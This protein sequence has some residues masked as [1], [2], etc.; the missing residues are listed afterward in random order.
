MIQF[1]RLNY[2]NIQNLNFELMNIE[3]FEENSNKE[4]EIDEEIQ[5]TQNNLSSTQKPLITIKDPKKPFKI[6]NLFKYSSFQQK[7]LAFIAIIL[8]CLS[9]AAY[10]TFIYLYGDLNQNFAKNPHTSAYKKNVH[11]KIPYLLLLSLAAFICSSLGSG[12]WKFVGSKLHQKLRTLYFKKLIAQDS[13]F[14]DLKNSQILPG[15]F[16]RNFSEY[17]AAAGMAHYNICYSLSLLIN[18][19]GLALYQGI[20]FSLKLII[21][22]LVPIAFCALIALAYYW[23]KRGASSYEK[24]EKAEFYSEQAISCIKVVKSL[25]AEHHEEQRFKSQS[26]AVS[27]HKSALEW[28]QSSLFALWMMGVYFFLH[29]LYGLVFIL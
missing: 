19:L 16:Y 5:N 18:G 15:R 26:K 14:Y 27:A 9:G 29:V 17:R 25:G 7:I 6:A 3:N 23:L 22:G 4:I 21:F 1:F 2:P 24:E 11:K 20:D 28:V 10:P 12:I 8:S 13:S